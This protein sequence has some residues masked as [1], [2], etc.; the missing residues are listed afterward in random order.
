MDPHLVMM[1]FFLL[2]VFPLFL[3]FLLPNAVLPL[4]PR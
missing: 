3:L 4:P 1:F 2:L